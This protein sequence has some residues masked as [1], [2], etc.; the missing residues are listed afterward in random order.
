MSQFLIDKQTLNELEVFTKSSKDENNSLFKWLDYCLSAGGKRHLKKRLGLPFRTIEDILLVQESLEHLVS[1]LNEWELPIEAEQMFFIEEYLNSNTFPI[2]PNSSLGIFVESSISSLLNK[3]SFETLKVQINRMT[4]FLKAVA[5]FVDRVN[6]PQLPTLLDRMIAK[7]DELLNL[8]TLQTVLKEKNKYSAYQIHHYDKIFRDGDYPKNE[9]QALITIVG[10][11]Y[12]LDALLSMAKAVKKYQLCFPNWQSE[13]TGIIIKGLYHPF[14][15]KPIKNTIVL[16][17]PQHFIF[18]TGANMAG[19][20]TFMKAYSTCLYLAHLGMGVPAEY[21]ELK[22][23]DGLFTSINT[24]DNLSMDYSFFYSE[25]RRVKEALVL[26]KQYPRIFLMFDELF[27]GTNVKDA[28]DCS[29]LII[30][31]LLSKSETYAI[32]SS[33]LL[34]LAQ[35]FKNR[36]GLEFYKFES[37]VIENKAHFNYQLKSGISD[38]RLGL[39]ILKNEG[40]EELLA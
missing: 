37:R 1:Q 29:Q 9:C 7:L 15:E 38:D 2:N 10:L 21:M 17:Y 5:H 27:K 33:H 16:D 28:Y 32:L 30:E 14:L 12:E 19:K 4:H 36:K 25:V 20:T 35:D 13:D 3:G 26:R 24:L 40:V 6:S 22:P 23:L 31:G 18:L 34:E 11:M 39:V 8:K